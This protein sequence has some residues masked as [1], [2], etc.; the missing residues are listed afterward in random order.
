MASGDKAGTQAGGSTTAGGTNV[1]NLDPIST[2]Q[3]LGNLFNFKNIWIEKAY[4]TYTPEW[5]KVGDADGLNISGLEVTAG[6]FNNPF[7]KGQIIR[8]THIVR[9]N[10]GKYKDEDGK[11]MI[12]YENTENGA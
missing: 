6:K 5:A 10:G 3:T 8:C 7:E 9:Q 1:G 12:G 4:A 2:N 11:L